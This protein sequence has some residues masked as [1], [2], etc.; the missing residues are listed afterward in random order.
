MKT[1]ILSA[2]LL[3][4]AMMNANA[5]S[6]LNGGFEDGN[7]NGW[8]QGGGFWSSPSTYPNAGDPSLYQVGGTRYNANYIANSVVGVG[9]DARTGGALQTVKYGNYA[10]RINDPNENYS[11]STIKQTVS[12]YDG[13]S[14]NFAWAAVLEAS[15]GATDSDSFAL[16]VTDDTTGTVLYTKAYN[17]YANGSLFHYYSPSGAYYTDWQEVSLNVT[18]GHT[19]TITLL[20]A[21][22]P[23]GGH[24]GY[25]YLDGFGTTVGGPGDNGSGNNVPEPSGFALAGLAA[26]GAVFASRRRKQAAA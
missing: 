19:F 21:D 20:A 12:N 18:K 11:V 25:A 3:G 16:K 6:F 2:C 15:H 10:A 4:M 23:Y 9:T 17:S 13:T 14:I 5:A 7:L 24:W 26:F 22:C 1:K 8:T